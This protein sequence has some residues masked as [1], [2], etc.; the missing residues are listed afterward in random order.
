MQVEH[1][2]EQLL[3]QERYGL[4]A[5]VGSRW[6]LP[7]QHAWEQ[8][9]QSL[10]LYGSSLSVCVSQHSGCCPVNTRAEVWSATLTPFIPE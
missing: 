3:Q 8:W 4:A 9:A 6:Q 5:Y 10:I 2:M 1:L 7:V